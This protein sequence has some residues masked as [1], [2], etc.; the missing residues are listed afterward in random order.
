MTVR[1]NRTGRKY[2]WSILIDQDNLASHCK[3]R[4]QQWSHLPWTQERFFWYAVLWVFPALGIHSYIDVSFFFFL[5]KDMQEQ[6]FQKSLGTKSLVM[7]TGSLCYFWRSLRQVRYLSP[8]EISRSETSNLST[9]K[10][11]ASA[12]LHF[13]SSNHL[14][15]SFSYILI[16]LNW[17]PM[18]FML[19][20]H[21]KSIFH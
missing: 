2:F 18:F 13:Q 19:S 10:N 8:T 4:N 5:I 7:Q 15:I 11:L 20:P 17:L 16:Y 14:W 21:L 12:Y 9:Q 1:H 3:L 6:I